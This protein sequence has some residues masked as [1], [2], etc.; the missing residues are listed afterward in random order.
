MLPVQSL[1]LTH[2]ASTNLF[3]LIKNMLAKVTDSFQKVWV[4]VYSR[5]KKKTSK[6]I[7]PTPESLAPLSI[8]AYMHIHGAHGTVRTELVH[9][10]CRCTPV[11]SMKFALI[12]R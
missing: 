7:S 6:Y 9:L 12:G 3:L 5:K 8:P 11:M 1:H 10:L 2:D 4:L